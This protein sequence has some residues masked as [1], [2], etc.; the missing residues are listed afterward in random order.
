MTDYSGPYVRLLTLGTDHS[1]AAPSFTLFTFGD[2]AR[3]IQPTRDTSTE[4]PSR[5]ARC[6]GPTTGDPWLV[7]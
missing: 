3:L 5:T 1:F 4:V 6:T 7:I 2:C